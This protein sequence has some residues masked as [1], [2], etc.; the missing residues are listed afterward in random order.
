MG[1]VSYS[2]R[3]STVQLALP[4]G[5][6]EAISTALRALAK[7]LAVAKRTASPRQQPTDITVYKHL[8]ETGGLRWL[9]ALM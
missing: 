3:L 5:R 7:S 9:I 4:P 8:A 6:G 1:P 2:A